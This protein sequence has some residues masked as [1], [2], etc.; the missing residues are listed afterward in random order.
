MT[1]VKFVEVGNEIIVRE[2][3]D[4]EE[5]EKKYGGNMENITTNWWP[6][7]PSKGKIMDFN[8]LV[9]MDLQVYFILGKEEDLKLFPADFNLN[10]S[11]SK[12]ELNRSKLNKTVV[13]NYDRIEKSKKIK[14][15]QKIFG[16]CCS[17]RD[18][19]GEKEQLKT[20]KEQTE[21]S[22]TDLKSS[23]VMKKKKVPN[24][25]TLDNNGMTNVQIDDNT[26]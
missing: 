2:D 15:Y 19:K 9:E 22:V 6:P 12:I 13:L 21:Q 18:T 20:I 14:W 8:N 16:S 26:S 25:V 11:I 7:K 17:E 23:K 24:G 3:L 4:P 10:A 1:K 5:L